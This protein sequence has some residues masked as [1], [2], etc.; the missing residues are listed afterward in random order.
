MMSVG[1][2][3]MTGRRVLALLP[4]SKKEQTQTIIGFL[5]AAKARWDIEVDVVCLEIDRGGFERLAAPADRF[6]FVPHLLQPQDWERDPE[7]V[8][9]VEGRIH[10]AELAAGHPIGRL[11]L[12]AAHNIGRA[13]NAPMRHWRRYAIVRRVLRDNSEAFRIARRLFRFADDVLAV[14]A[15][16]FICAY[17]YA[18]ALNAAFQL[19]AKLHGIPCVVSRNS[20]INS[21]HA[22]W[23]TDRLML[24]TMAIAVGTAKRES[25]APVS[26]AANA[27][28]RA[29]REQPAT[30]HYIASKWQY[31]ARSGF[32]RWHLQYARTI[33]RELVSRS[34]GADRALAE[35]LGSRLALYYWQILMTYRHQRFLHSFDDAALAKM[36]YVYFPMH[37]EAELALALQAT[38]WYDQRNTIRLLASMLPF[39]YR[40]L[41]RE[42][43]LNYGHRPTRIYRELAQI[44]NVVVIDPFDS[45]FKYLRHADLVVT[46]NGSSG[47]EGLLLGRRVLLLSETFYDGTGLGMR[48]TDPDRINAAILETL[49][50]PPVADAAAHDHALACMIDAELETT[51]PMSREGTRTALD[52]LAA[53]LSPVLRRHGSR[54]PADVCDAV[55]SL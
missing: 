3:E 42:N 35:T 26:H 17:E 32:L 29:F 52:R 55:G 28:L 25:G 16:D 19:A 49:A 2:S 14:A 30:V 7:Q 21:G 15:P 5:E 50:K 37:K 31:V 40:L 39:G 46:E 10:E 23:S 41:V 8:A 38:Q 20:K 43:R 53:T 36:K 33:G 13:F 44:P 51:F 11:V 47:W 45:Q 4:P 6:F 27:R 34:K 54:M 18:V 24:N 22:F 1:T 9:A 12:G 48:V